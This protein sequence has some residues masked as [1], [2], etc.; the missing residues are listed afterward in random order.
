MVEIA[1]PEREGGGERAPLR[2]ALVLDR[3]GSMAGQKLRVAK[4]CAAWLLDRL[5]PTDEIALV[6]Y[7][8]HVRT[9]S[10]LARPSAGALSRLARIGARRLDEPLG[11]LAEG[12]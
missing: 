3:S 12:V 10:P 1:V 11:R 9:L 6:T 4:R 7:D 8:D 5:R 2:L